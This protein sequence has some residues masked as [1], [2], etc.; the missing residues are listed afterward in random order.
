M[1]DKRISIF[2]GHFGSGKTEIAVNTAVTLSEGGNNTAI[3]DLDIANPYFRAADAKDMFFDKGIRFICP[4]YAN[5]NVDVPALPPEINTLFEDKTTKVVLDIGGDDI[6]ARVLA[7]YIDQFDSGSYEMFF[8]INIKRPMTDTKDKIKEVISEIEDSSRLK[9]SKL[10]SNTNL[11][12]ST[13]VED[14]LEGLSITE[15]VSRDLSIPIAFV[16]CS[17]SLENELK[18]KIYYPILPLRGFINLPW[19]I[20]TV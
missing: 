7:R 14:I 8:V 17:E 15:E 16:A 19:N 4:M 3:V 6:G 1:F 10:I 20:N 11:L 13:T 5:T 18:D 9:V 2:T 12:D